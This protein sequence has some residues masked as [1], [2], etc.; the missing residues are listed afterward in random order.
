LLVGKLSFISSYSHGI[1]GD[2]PLIF[3]LHAIR[4]FYHVSFF[5]CFNFIYLLG[6]WR[7]KLSCRLNLQ[8]CY[9][10]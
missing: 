3:F 7:H 4:K 8:I 10:R 9:F 2:A 6:V 1:G 5:I